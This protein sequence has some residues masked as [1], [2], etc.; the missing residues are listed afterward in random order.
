M[1]SPEAILLPVSLSLSISP[2]AVDAGAALTLSAVAKCPE[3]YD[4]SGDPVLFLDATGHEVG[5]APLAALEGND[6]G[7]EIAVTAPI[8]PGEH[9]YSVVLTPA[10]GDGVAHA[11]AKAGARCTVKAHDVHLNAWDI[12]SAIGAGEAFSFHVGLRCSCGCNL[13]NRDFVVRDQEGTVVASGR[14]GEAIWPGTSALYFAEVRA[15]APA[16]ISLH[17]WMV[18]SAGWNSGIAHSPGSLGIDVRTVAAPD[19]EITIE[20]VDRESGAPLE[21]VNLIMHPYR[22]TT[23]RNGMARMKVA[24]D[25]YMLHASGL[26]CLPYED[27]LDATRPVKLRI[28]MAVELPQFEYMPRVEQKPSIAE[29]LR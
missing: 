3:D 16:D 8:E 22:A 21:G 24:A 18:E 2:R 29:V 10:K 14:L 28:L 26:K 13:A 9:G 19:H 15:V 23:D 4:L 5:S 17:P 11:G 1:T 27:H 20:V 7:A 25:H 6:F 12:P